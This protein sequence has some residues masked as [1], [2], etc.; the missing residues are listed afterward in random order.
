MET[1]LQ[2]LKLKRARLLSEIEMLS[3]V[4]DT[5]FINLGKVTSEIHFLEKAI[6][7]QT[8]NTIDEH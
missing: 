4:S 5:M 3:E 7:R 2:S 8:E 1:K 6:V